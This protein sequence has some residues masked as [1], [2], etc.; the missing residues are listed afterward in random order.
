MRTLVPALRDVLNEGAG[1]GLEPDVHAFLAKSI[2][3]QIQ[4]LEDIQ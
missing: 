3:S 4:A 2:Q 1:F